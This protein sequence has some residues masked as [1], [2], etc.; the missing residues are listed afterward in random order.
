MELCILST[1][2]I[3]VRWV[4]GLYRD[5]AQK[6]R[7]KTLVLA[8]PI[9]PYP[10]SKVFA[11]DRGTPLDRVYIEKFLHANK[12][13][14]SGYCLE[15]ADCTYLDRY[16][17]EHCSKHALV[18]DSLSTGA[19]GDQNFCFDL[20]R[21]ETAPANKFDTFICT[22]TLNFIFD[23]DAAIATIHKVLKP[24]GCAL[25]TVAGI[26]QISKY[27]YE[28]WGDFWRFTDLSLR[29]L[30]TKYFGEAGV[31]ISTYGNVAAACMF[32][33]GLSFEEIPAKSILDH[34]DPNYQMVIC[35]LVNKI[36]Q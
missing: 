14:I 1:S 3:T 5:V 20:S 25:I 8:C 7:R 29:R 26:C 2:L 15:V 24:G 12:A 17:P 30:L 16:G 4:K 34:V 27:D 13:S 19:D 22:Q 28:R 31:K 18:Y 6:I 32:L 10:V 35:A 36:G 21:Q 9:D 33:Q 23:V 11:L